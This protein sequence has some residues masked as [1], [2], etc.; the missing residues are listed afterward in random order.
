MIRRHLSALGKTSL[1]VGCLA[2]GIVSGGTSD[3]FARSVAE[4][5]RPFVA[6]GTVPGVI[7]ASRVDGCDFVESVGL[8]AKT[9]IAFSREFAEDFRKKFE[10][11]IG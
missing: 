10:A 9:S 11:C 5:V 8:D 2:A 4:A 7:V 6:D 1:R 3:A